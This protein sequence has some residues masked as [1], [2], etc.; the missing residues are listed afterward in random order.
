MR[1]RFAVH[2]SAPQ[3]EEVLEA[4]G[5]LFTPSSTCGCDLGGAVI[6]I[7]GVG[8]ASPSPAKCLCVSG[9][10]CACA[11]GGN[12]QAP[13]SA[14]YSA[15]SAAIAGT[16][17]AS[18]SYR[19]QAVC[20][21]T[22]G[23]VSLP[24]VALPAAVTSSGSRAVT[25]GLCGCGVSGPK[26]EEVCIA[27]VL[28][29]LMLLVPPSRRRLGDRPLGADCFA[30]AAI[31]VSV[32]ATSAIVSSCS[33]RSSASVVGDEGAVNR[34]EQPTFDASTIHLAPLIDRARY[35]A[36]LTLEVMEDCRYGD[37]RRKFTVV[38]SSPSAPIQVPMGPIARMLGCYTRAVY[39]WAVR[40]FTAAAD[41]HIEL[42]PDG[43]ASWNLSGDVAES[44]ELTGYDSYYASSMGIFRCVLGRTQL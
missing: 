12:C 43:G 44:L 36:R 24:F 18:V 40:V 5:R 38:S 16:E 30:V 14:V 4:L 42:S 19:I 1:L 11:A 23:G 33:T 31:G 32:T 17:G 13:L 34:F 27:A 22:F 26:A 6:Q 35:A 3:R 9:I 20:A 21:V 15:V 28:R 7:S 10:G 8:C 39:D 25:K 2:R 29:R 41:G 37:G